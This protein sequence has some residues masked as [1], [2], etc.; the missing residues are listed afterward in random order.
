MEA[1]ETRKAVHQVWHMPMQETR[2]VQLEDYMEPKDASGC[3]F[4]I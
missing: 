4:P 3:L 1:T 2:A